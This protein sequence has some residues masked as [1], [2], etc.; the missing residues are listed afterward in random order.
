EHTE[1]CW[2]L[3]TVTP[4]GELERMTQYK[5]KAARQADNINAGL[6]DYPVLQAADILLYRATM[7]PVGQ[8]Q[9]QHLE[10][11]R[12]IGRRSNATYG[13]TFAEPQALLSP[14]PKILGLDGAAKMSKTAG[15][16]IGLRESSDEMWQKLRVAVT[17]PARVKRTD[18]GNPD[19]CNV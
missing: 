9:L 12:E 6:F 18:P 1:L 16:T 17:D 7:V 3:N 14:T 10:L 2:I 8:D 15:N 13:D 19:I 11:P 4:K 5:D